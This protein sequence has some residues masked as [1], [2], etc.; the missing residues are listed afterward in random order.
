MKD[1]KCRNCDNIVPYKQFIDGK[2]RNFQNR[3]YCLECSPY[4][5]HNTKP[6]I[7][8]KTMK[9][10]RAYKDWDEDYKEIFRQK[11]Y[12]KRYEKKKKLLE[13]SGNKCSVCGYDKCPDALSFH[14][15]DKSTKTFGLSSDIIN[16]KSWDTILEEWKKCILV[17]MN[18]HAEIHYNERK[19]GDYLDNLQGDTEML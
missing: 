3:K 5:K 12:R 9:G 7:N 17:C 13:M 4:G 11:A 14:H 10:N 19:I 16:S 6:D 2:I 15:L 1:R 18:C 8:A